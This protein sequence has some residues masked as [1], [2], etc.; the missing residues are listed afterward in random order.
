M[1][2]AVTVIPNTAPLVTTVLASSK[3]VNIPY[4]IRL[5]PIY[6]QDIINRHQCVVH[7]SGKRC[8]M[9]LL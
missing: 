3:E 2:R 1:L 4:T 7:Y 8:R 5:K 9:V 6:L